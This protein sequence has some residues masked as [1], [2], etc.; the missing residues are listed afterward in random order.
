MQRVVAP[1]LGSVSPRGLSV[2]QAV[3]PSARVP[4]APK[5][6]V[7]RTFHVVPRSAVEVAQLADFQVESGLFYLPSWTSDQL[8]GLAFGVL[9][10][11]AFYLTR[12]F[13]EWVAVQQREELGLCAKCGGLND[14]EECREGG[15]PGAK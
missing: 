9:M 14:P 8:A 7:R 1:S 12:N 10:V 11:A 4:L 6:H 3:H 2:L 15:C 13:D 5:R